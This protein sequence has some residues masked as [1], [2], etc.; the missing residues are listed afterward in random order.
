VIYH[1]LPEQDFRITLAWMPIIGGNKV[2]NVV[3]MDATI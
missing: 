1:T 2:A 3:A